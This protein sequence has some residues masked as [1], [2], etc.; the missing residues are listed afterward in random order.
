MIHR[1]S[2]QIPRVISQPPFSTIKTIRRLSFKISTSNL[3]SHSERLQE[4]PQVNK[5]T[6]CILLPFLVRGTGGN[7]GSSHQKSIKYITYLK[8]S[9]PLY[10][11]RMDNFQKLLTEGL[12]NMPNLLIQLD[13]LLFGICFFSLHIS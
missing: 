13:C 2:S 3:F 6:V 4:S 12:F 1:I 5:F 10:S 11:L 9:L 8:K 7:K